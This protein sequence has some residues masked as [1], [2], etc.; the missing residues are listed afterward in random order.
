MIR[1][2]MEAA[3]LVIWPMITLVLFFVSMLA[4]LLWVWRKDSEK[5]YGHL[6]QLVLEEDVDVSQKR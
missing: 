6:S 5:V 4:M 1:E 2:V 3:N